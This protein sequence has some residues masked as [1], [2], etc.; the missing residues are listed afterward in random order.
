MSLILLI[1]TGKVPVEGIAASRILDDISPGLV[2]I[3]AVVSS[4]IEKSWTV[5]VGE[6]LVGY[7]HLCLV[8]EAEDIVASHGITVKRKWMRMIGGYDDQRLLQFH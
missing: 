3:C 5:G 7:L 4:M 8:T 6:R 2:H 1:V